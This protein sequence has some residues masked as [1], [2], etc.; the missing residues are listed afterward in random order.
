MSQQPR[1]C[2][3]CGL[4]QFAFTCKRWI[5]VS[6]TTFLIL[7]CLLMPVTATARE[8]GSTFHYVSS[9][10]HLYCRC[11]RQ[12]KFL[13]SFMPLSAT[14]RCLL[15]PCPCTDGRC[16]EPRGLF[17]RLRHTVPVRTGEFSAQD[18]TWTESTLCLPLFTHLHNGAS[19]EALKAAG[20]RWWGRYFGTKGCSTRRDKT[21]CT[22]ELSRC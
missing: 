20:V 2:K 11:K 12:V 6:P 17:G 3:Q 4:A 22:Q 8:T 1:T 19:R 13:C 5:S 9:K 7:W 10:E 16:R 21:W 15:L 18:N 14:L